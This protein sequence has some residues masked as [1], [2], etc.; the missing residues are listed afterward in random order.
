MRINVAIVL[1]AL[2]VFA[3]GY[4][5]QACAQA[6]YT[7]GIPVVAG[8][9]NTQLAPLFQELVKVVGGKLGVKA[10]T[11]LI[12]YEQGD[13]ILKKVL[14]E[15]DSKKV[16]ITLLFGQEYSEFQATG[17]T[18][19]IPIATLSAAGQAVL[20]NC[21]YVRKGEF[22]SLQELRGKKWAG[23][24]YRPTRY[25]LYK[26]GIDEP[27]D[28]FFGSIDYANDSPITLIVKGLEEKQYDA[29]ASYDSFVKISGMMT[30][31]DVFFEPLVCE[32][33]DHS[34]IFVARKEIPAATIEQFRKV[35][36]GA[37]KDPDF[38]KFQFAFQMVAGKF[39]P[40][41]ADDVKFVRQIFD[42]G[43]KNGWRKEENAF[44]KKFKP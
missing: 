23:A 1:A 2:T 6:R 30:K 20:S 44:F 15:V 43:I 12:I 4:A 5:N 29:F 16:D 17:R 26:K 42:L 28:K 37:A 19:L 21:L 18:D 32:K 34:W 41:K 38:G 27:L 8:M 25:L 31:K 7:V 24:S 22:K 40:V 35:L 11:K 13:D 33:Y 14:S 10:E 9:E 3:F 39:Q 36:M